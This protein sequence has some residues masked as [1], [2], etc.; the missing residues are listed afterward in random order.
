MG[1]K[2]VKLACQGCGSDLTLN[3]DVRFVT[4][5]FCGSKLEVVHD[6]SVTHTR[7]LENIA[8]DLKVIQAQNELEQLDR[9]WA[10]RREGFMVQDKDG[11][12]SIPHTGISV[13]MGGF[14]VVA[15]IVWMIAASAMGAPSIFVMFGL[16]FIGVAIV[17]AITSAKKAGGYQSAKAA[18][19]ARR[20]ELLRKIESAKGQ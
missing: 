9:E 16:V 7:L 18:H 5:N 15:G 1:T 17:G 8:G 11:H 13:A 20:S 4:C 10:Q 14:A 6:Q 2:I 19:D 12:R 3:E